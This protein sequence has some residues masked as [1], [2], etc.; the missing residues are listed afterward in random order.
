[1]AQMANGNWRAS[2]YIKELSPVRINGHKPLSKFTDKSLKFCTYFDK[3]YHGGILI[4]YMLPGGFLDVIGKMTIIKINVLGKQRS[5]YVDGIYLSEDMRGRGLTIPIYKS[6]IDAGL[7][8]TGGLTQFIGARKLWEK[9]SNRADFK[10]DIYDLQY[11]KYMYYNVKLK[12]HNDDRLWDNGNGY[13]KYY[14]S[15]A[16]TK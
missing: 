3:S 13:N 5:V 7:T 16:S 10:V 2:K 9:L 15:V 11:K 4:G 8:I 6:I 14:I 1:M 12:N